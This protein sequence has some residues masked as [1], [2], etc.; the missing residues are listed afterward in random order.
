MRTLE[1]RKV[2]WSK[3]RVTMRVLCN[4]LCNMFI[5]LVLSLFAG[6]D[7]ICIVFTS[8]FVVAMVVPAV[9]GAILLDR[10]NAVSRDTIPKIS[11]STYKGRFKTFQLAF[12]TV[13]TIFL[14]TY[15]VVSEVFTK[16]LNFVGGMTMA[17]IVYAA[18]VI[19]SSLMLTV[20]SSED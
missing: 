1:L 13:A 17:A 10:E 16:Y 14:V 20:N 12:A 8:L 7:I 11:I 19:A 9:Y 3:Y 4:C 6:S 18:I 5:N 2:D 15:L